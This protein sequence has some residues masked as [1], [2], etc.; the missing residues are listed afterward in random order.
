MLSAL[1]RDHAW[2][3]GELNGTSEVVFPWK[4]TLLSFDLQLYHLTL[5][6]LLLILNVLLNLTKV[7][8]NCAEAISEVSTWVFSFALLLAAA[9]MESPVSMASLLQCKMQEFAFLARI[10][11]VNFSSN[12]L[13]RLLYFLVK[14]R[15]VTVPLNLWWQKSIVIFHN[16]LSVHWCQTQTCW[17]YA[18]QSRHR[19]K[20]PGKEHPATTPKIWWPERGYKAASS[21]LCFPVACH[22][23]WCLHYLWGS[24]PAQPYLCCYFS[25]VFALLLP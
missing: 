13:Q 2:S 20:T 25:K 4:F 10:I 24:P 14:R 1:G 18:F 5:L 21:H 3:L 11:G 6:H 15:A 8:G 16:Q 9:P 23:R 22:H 12:P 7:Q 19:A 17:S